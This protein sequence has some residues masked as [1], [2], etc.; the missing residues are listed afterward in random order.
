[1]K[2]KI[3]FALPAILLFC[4]NAYCD[5]PS[6]KLA[7]YESSMT[8]YGDRLPLEQREAT[9]TPAPIIVITR[10]DIESSGAATIQQLLE[11]VPGVSVRDLTG[12]PSEK[13]VDLRGF[14]EGTSV[15]VFLD[16]VRLNNLE[17][18]SARWEIVPLDQVERIEVYSGAL[19]PLYGGGAIGGVVNIVTKKGNGIPRLDLT[20]GIGSFGETT[21]KLGA[22]GTLGKWDIYA[23]FG[24]S[25]SE[26]YRENDGHR[27][28]DGL[29]RVTYNFREGESLS[30]LTKYSG[31]AVSA[32]GALTGEELRDD[33]R[34]SP[35]NLYD[36][37]R[38]RHRLVS[39]SYN[40][41]FGESVNISAE[42]FSR[43]HDRDTLTT[44]RYMS[45]FFTTGEEKLGGG[46]VQVDGRT[47]AGKGVFEWAFSGE[48]SDG[49]YDASGWY[50]D[51]F[52]NKTF[53][54]TRTRTGQK[55]SGGYARLGFTL[56]RFRMDAGY[57]VDEAKYD[58]Q[59]R[60]NPSS[61]TRRVFRE[62][63]ARLSASFLKSES[64]SFFLAFSEGYRIPGVI[65][66]FAYP[67]FYS[68]PDLK[69]TRV[70]D[71]EAGYKYFG[72]KL[73]AN[74]TLYKM[75]LRDETVFILTDPAHFI[76]QN[77]N[78]GKSKRTG[79]EGE[80]EFYLPRNLSL[81]L[82]GSLRNC[83]ATAGP[84]DGSDIPMTPDGSLNL[85]LRWRGGKFSGGG[86]INYV[87]AQFLSNDLQNER[88]KLGSYT[89]ASASGRYKSGPVTVELQVNNLFD[90]KYSTR[91]VTNGFTDYFTPA[92]PFN[93]RILVTYSW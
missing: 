29:L 21:E 39:L 50:T 10:D 83:E 20:A 3:R 73:R 35:Y 5:D 87:G 89:T 84:Y 56:S 60:M 61:D 22:S 44:G 80:T 93:A 67:G 25:C 79:V 34:Q 63:T 43:I 11:S 31:G 92:Y 52:G 82:S 46:V 53:A 78:V 72:D 62:G 77:M 28:D 23:G 12:N 58:Y 59:D 71:F 64:E 13:T 37:T 24:L 15:S 68:N 17:D 85:G 26:G 86:E 7:L 66:L 4:L 47:P 14:P 54:A 57:R 33:R 51:F 75:F 69:P 74:V 40:R 45:G 70:N 6:R 36:G 88:G 9:L 27:L 41:S 16:G 30:L 32:P 19:A 76:G 48:S 49:S 8:V 1:M 2:P 42:G 55:T 90:R 81:S 91:G 38:G 18:N 65:E